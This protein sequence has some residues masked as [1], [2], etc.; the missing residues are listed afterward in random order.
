MSMNKYLDVSPEVAAAVAAF[1]I[2]PVWGLLGGPAVSVAVN[3][4]FEKKG[5]K[6]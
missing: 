1:K 5:E 3:M 2:S 6:A 4:I